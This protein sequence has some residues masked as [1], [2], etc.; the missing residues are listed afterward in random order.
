MKGKRRHPGLQTSSLSFHVDV[1][2][3]SAA[4][5]VPLSG[6]S[7]C[8]RG[9][10]PS[11]AL[12]LRMHPTQFPTLRH[13]RLKGDSFKVF[14]LSA[15]CDRRRKQGTALLLRTRASQDQYESH[16]RGKQADKNNHDKPYVR[17]F[18]CSVWDKSAT[19]AADSDDGAND[20][21]AHTA[22]RYQQDCSSPGLVEIRW[23]KRSTGE[24]SACAL[25]RQNS[26]G[27]CQA[28]TSERRRKLGDDFSSPLLS[29][30]AVVGLSESAH[31]QDLGCNLPVPESLASKPSDMQL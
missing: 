9:A 3:A 18:A 11:A 8:P 14:C 5:A 26:G 2:V 17:A 1:A 28:R 4:G 21:P 22:S 29:G 13:S 6:S 27:E 23:K 30:P 20:I 10:G 15:T 19:K 7:E 24:G 31:V 12:W 16:E 25:D